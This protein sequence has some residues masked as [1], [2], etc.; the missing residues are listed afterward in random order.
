M[1][2]IFLLLVEFS[3]RG[4][5]FEILIAMQE[6]RFA[7]KRYLS[8]AAI[9]GAAD[10]D[11]LASQIK[12]KSWLPPA[13]CPSTLRDRFGWIGNLQATATPL[14]PSHPAEARAG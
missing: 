13:M 3:N 10:G 14:N 2:D 5:T 12:K 7:F 9:N 1:V 11:P 4:D 6:Q 8:Y